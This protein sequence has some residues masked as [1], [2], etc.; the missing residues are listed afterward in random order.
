MK[1]TYITPETCAINLETAEVL[2]GSVL[3]GAGG[4]NTN[5]SVSDEEAD[6]FR[7]QKR[8]WSSDLWNN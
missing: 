3:N 4:E 1:K 5:I 6:E 2:A 7:S 8:G